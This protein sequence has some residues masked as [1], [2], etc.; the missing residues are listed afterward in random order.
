MTDLYDMAT[1]VEEGFRA[2]ALAAQ[3]AR[4]PRGE[5]ATHCADCGESIPRAR[6]EAAPGCRRCT[7]CENRHER[8]RGR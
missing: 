5:A 4:S 8:R 6:R 3:R 2:Q 1:E 7:D